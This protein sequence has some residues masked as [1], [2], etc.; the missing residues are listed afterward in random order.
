MCVCVSVCPRLYA[1]KGK[2]LKLS[3]PNSID[4]RGSRS[5]NIDVKVKRSKS[6][7]YAV[8]KCAASVG[9]HIDMNA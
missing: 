4:I 8:I 9:V 2:R 7:V 5:A 3:T 6:Q 1:L